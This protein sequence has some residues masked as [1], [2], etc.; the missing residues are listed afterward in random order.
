M[1][2]VSEGIATGNAGSPFR[3]RISFGT[4]NKREVMHEWTAAT[5]RDA[6]EQADDWLH[7][8]SARL[9]LGDDQLRSMKV[10][11]DRWERMKSIVGCPDLPEP[12]EKYCDAIVNHTDDAGEAP[13]VPTVVHRTQ[14]SVRYPSA[15]RIARTVEHVRKAGLHPSGVRVWPD[16]SIAVFDARYA[17]LSAPGTSEDRPVLTNSLSNQIVFD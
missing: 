5:L 4:R 6:Q 11:Q 14:R 10:M 16:G 2:I 9:G 7:E 3:A 8:Y 17:P 12:G 13:G 1:Q 15:S